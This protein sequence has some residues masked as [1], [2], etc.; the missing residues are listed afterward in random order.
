[1]QAGQHGACSG[2]DS[3]IWARPPVRA[4][5][6]PLP[7]SA[8]FPLHPCSRDALSPEALNIASYDTRQRAR[9]AQGGGGL[10][11][12]L[13][14]AIRDIRRAEGGCAT[15]GGAAR[16]LVGPPHGHGN[17]LPP[18]GEAVA[19]LHWLAMHGLEAGDALW[20][21]HAAACLPACVPCRFYFAEAPVP[22][23]EHSELVE[24]VGRAGQS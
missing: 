2:A 7:P 1:M 24:V 16:W 19:L 10:K 21:A 14:Q 9:M 20:R 12:G 15:P 5:P 4:E 6:F 18:T 17:V 11:S 22:P 13:E 8:A 23:E 3:R